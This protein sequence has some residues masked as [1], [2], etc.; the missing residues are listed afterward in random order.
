MPRH[1]DM[2]RTNLEAAAVGPE[3]PPDV[4][5]GG[6]RAQA[7]QRL[8]IGVAGVVLM[9]LMVGLASLV[10]DRADEVET[11]VVP[12]AAPTVE[13]KE[14][15]AQNDPLVEAGVVPDLPAEPSP[16]PVQSPATTPQQPAQGAPAPAQ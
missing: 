7:I 16:T 15:G 8:Q 4:P 1:M 14:A 5:L 13:P 3:I 6:T 12:E 10:R 11:G 2:T 9:V